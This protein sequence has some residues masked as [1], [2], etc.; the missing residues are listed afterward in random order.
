MK[1]VIETIEDIIW[2][3][4][5][6]IGIFLIAFGNSGN[7]WYHYG[8]LASGIVMTILIGLRIIIGKEE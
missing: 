7:A 3:A 6:C 2:L 5:L 8:S 1:K 4:L